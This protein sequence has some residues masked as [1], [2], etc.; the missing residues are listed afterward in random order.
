MADRR[1]GLWAEIA[2]A[3]ALLS[4]ATILLNAALF[5]LLGN[6]L[7]LERRTDLALSAAKPEATGD[8]NSVDVVQA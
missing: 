3:L 1:P 5:W 6:R 2:L 7:E 4:L 8:Q